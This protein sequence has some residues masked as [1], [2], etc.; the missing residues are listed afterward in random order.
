MEF[1]DLIPVAS[2][3]IRQVRKR[4][5]YSRTYKFRTRRRDEVQ[6]LFVPHSVAANR[7]DA[8]MH[9]G[10]SKACYKKI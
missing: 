2:E 1:D 5:V 4:W 7:C 8:T 10:Y 6:L 3:A 9:H